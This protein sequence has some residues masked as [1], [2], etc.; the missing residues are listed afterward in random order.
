M[1]KYYLRHPKL[2]WR[3]S[4]CVSPKIQS[5]NTITDEL[6]TRTIP[7]IKALTQLEY[8]VNANTVLDRLEN[9][10]FDKRLYQEQQEFLIEFSQRKNIKIPE[11]FTNAQEQ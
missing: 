8:T 7:K 1:R 9:S 6:R 5:F 11:E 2:S 4:Y 3:L 10:K